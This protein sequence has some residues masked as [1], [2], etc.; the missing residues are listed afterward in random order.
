MKECT[1]HPK[2]NVIDDKLSYYFECVKNKQIASIKRNKDQIREFLKKNTNMS[3]ELIEE[4]IKRFDREDKLEAKFNERMKKAREDKEN[5]NN[6]I[7]STRF[8][9]AYDKRKSNSMQMNSFLNLSNARSNSNSKSNH[10]IESRSDLPSMLKDEDIKIKNKNENSIN[11][12]NYHNNNIQNIFINIGDFKNSRNNIDNH[13]PINKTNNQIM[14][15]YSVYGENMDNLLVQENNSLSEYL[16]N[17]SEI[18]TKSGS[19]IKKKPILNNYIPSN[20]YKTT[21]KNT[22]DMNKSYDYNNDKNI[23]NKLKQKSIFD[24]LYTQKLEKDQIYA[25]NMNDFSNRKKN[26]QL[27][28]SEYNYKISRRSSNLDNDSCISSLKS[29]LRNLNLNID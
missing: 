21:E 3:E 5:V 25:Y 7:S 27:N 17:D 23:T 16:K 18:L 26:S 28:L 19:Y 12:N 9:S 2:I 15:S 6:K 24:K 29:E 8:S 13:K 11:N 4:T 1:F 22:S 20:T 10:Y 14:K